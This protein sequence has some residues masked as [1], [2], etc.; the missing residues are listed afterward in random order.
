[1]EIAHNIDTVILD[2][3]GTITKGE[4]VVTD[5]LNFD[6]SK[7]KLLSI[8]YSLESGSEHPLG[9][10]IVKYSKENNIKSEDVEDF[11]AIFG[12]GI[13]AKLNKKEYYAGNASLM[14]D[15]KY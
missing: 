10:A 2:K 7:E 5:V 15:I 11:K 6:I 8:A 4:P 14:N 1:M 9:D 12:K 13:K 3:T